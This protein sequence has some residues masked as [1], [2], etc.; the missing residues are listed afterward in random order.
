M[1]RIEKSVFLSYRRTNFSWAL[2]IYQDLT[3]H[4]YDVFF[5]YNSIPAGDFETLIL[6]N[7]R[8]RAHFLVVLTPSALD[9]RPASVKSFSAKPKP[10]MLA[11]KPNAKPSE[12]PKKKQRWPNHP[13]Q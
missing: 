11:K 13:S 2:A 12:K 9:A 4:G 1:G 5:D 6:E 8:A 10:Y 7:V 3:Q